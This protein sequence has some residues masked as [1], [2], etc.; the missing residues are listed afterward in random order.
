MKQQ[1]DTINNMIKCLSKN[2][3]YAKFV[4][5]ELTELNKP[6]FRVTN[7]IT[8]EHVVLLYESASGLF[9]HEVEI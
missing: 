9:S 8:N 4:S 3:E 2:N 5:K 7:N 1:I 6:N